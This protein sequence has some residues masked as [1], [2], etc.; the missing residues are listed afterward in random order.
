MIIGLDVGGTHT[1]VVLLGDEGLHR[2]VKVHTN[3]AD[4][5]RTVLDSL[6]K[7]TADIDPHRIRRIVLSTTLTTNAIA[8]K[9]IPPVGMIVS[10]GPGLDPEWYRTGPHYFAV[11]GS[12]DHRGREVAPIDEEEILNIGDI[13]RQRGIRYVGVVGKF[14]VRNPRHERRIQAL[15]ED[16]FERVFMGHQVSGSLN[17]PR[18]VATTYLNAA[19]YPVHKGFFEAVEKSLAQKGLQVPLHILKADGGTMLLQAS[20]AFPGQTISSG[21]AAS[22]MGAV[23]YA[24]AETDVMVIDIGGTTTDLAVIRNGI[25]LLHPAGVRL[26]GLRTL[27]RSLETRS[28]AI[29]GDSHVNVRNG[30]LEIGPERED[31]A[32]AFGGR[33]PTPTDALVVLGNMTEGDRDEAVKGMAGVA[34]ALGVSTDD[35]ARLVFDKA[36]QTILAEVREMVDRINDRPVYTVQDLQHEEKVNPK[37]MLILGGPAPYFA[38]RLE[39]LSGISVRLVP[40]WQV[41]NAI[42]AALARTTCEVVVFADTQMGVAMAPEEEF[43]AEVDTHFTNRE[44]IEKAY[45]LLKA[46]ALQIGAS[47]EDLEME[48][49]ED[50]QFNM[51]R[52]FRTTG[53]N[54]RIKVQVKPGLI[55]TYER[56]IGNIDADHPNPRSN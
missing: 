17:F 50:L 20:M 31:I 40:R 6:E 14:S 15:I 11:G 29:G 38:K 7:I 3:T 55:G 18:R 26:G 8:Q 24:P 49:L 42:G 9:K 44:A 46:K 23:A 45:E 12:V 35:A 36:C 47:G 53:K 25:P 22:V 4:L 30:V 27:I 1:D 21:P 2:V 41:A 43:S 33:Y 19:V 13:L 5:F 34:A 54:I 28:I 10:S 37:R 39:A 48:V 32:M 16:R 52:G 56:I 51:V